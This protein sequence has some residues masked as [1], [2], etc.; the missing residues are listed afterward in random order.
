MVEIKRPLQGRVQ[1][2]LPPAGK[3]A[4]GHREW[5]G[6]VL[7]PLVRPSWTGRCW[8]IARAHYP[9]LVEAAV[10]EQ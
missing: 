5:F 1:A 7:S 2:F 9:V 8:E 6:L 4:G 3:G 10:E